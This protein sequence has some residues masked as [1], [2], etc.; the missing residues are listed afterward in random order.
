MNLAVNES[1]NDVIDARERTIADIIK[2][3]SRL[4]DFKLTD[5]NWK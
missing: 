1:S 4:L 3:K 2:H 5:F